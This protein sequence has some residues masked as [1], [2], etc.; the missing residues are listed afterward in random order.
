MDLKSLQLSDTTT[1]Q[2]LHPKTQIPTGITITLQSADSE[3]VRARIRVTTNQRIQQAQIAGK[4]VLTAEQREEESNALL[5]AAVC[6]WEGMVL[7][8]EPLPCTPD[9]VRMILCSPAYA[10][11]RRQVDAAFGDQAR[12]FE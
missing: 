11:I 7:D 8:D 12:F 6:S 9:N 2:I 5:C 10:W 4:L 3:A 1:I